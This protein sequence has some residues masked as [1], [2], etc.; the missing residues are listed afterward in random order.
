MKSLIVFLLILLG[1]DLMAQRPLSQTG[2]Q[3]T[4]VIRKNKDAQKISEE[5]EMTGIVKESVV[6]TNQ[7][8]KNAVVTM[9]ELRAQYLRD[10][11]MEL[12]MRG[13]EL[14]NIIWVPGLPANLVVKQFENG[15]EI[16]AGEMV[17]R[18][19]KI[20]LEVSNGQKR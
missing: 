14:G 8:F 1:F 17:K 18:G 15:I 10:A 2:K 3:G 13:L 5:E 4:M 7:L 12:K 11:R 19:A 20:I 6:T 9:P 16:K